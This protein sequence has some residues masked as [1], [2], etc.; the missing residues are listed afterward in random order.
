MANPAMFSVASSALSAATL[1]GVR[2]SQ[3]SSLAD[4]SAILKTKH[5]PIAGPSSQK[6]FNYVDRHIAFRVTSV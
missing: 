6:D 4:A 2:Y 5:S 1:V 3:G